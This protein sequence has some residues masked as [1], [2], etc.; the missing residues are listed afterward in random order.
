[1]RFSD[2]TSTIT[3]FRVF[4]LG[5]EA[6]ITSDAG[7]LTTSSF[8]A[9]ELGFEASMTVTV[10]G[11]GFLGGGDFDGSNIATSAELAES[12]DASV[13]RQLRHPYYSEL[14]LATW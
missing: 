13:G 14:D 6:S 5:F 3:S 1:M 12:S 2:S 4:E 11:G 10:G 7:V 9:L 8:G